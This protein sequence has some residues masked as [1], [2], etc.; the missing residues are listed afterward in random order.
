MKRTITL[1]LAVAATMALAAC[2]T[3]GGSGELPSKPKP[4]LAARY[5]AQLASNYMNEGRMDLARKKLALAMQQAPDLAV[6]HNVLALY[7][8][9]LGHY[10]KADEQYRISLHYKPND[11]DTLNNYGVFLCNRGKP[12][13][14]LQYFMRAA[15]DLNYPTPDSALANAGLCAQ[16]IPDAKL[17]AKYFRQ[18]LAVNPNQPQ[19]LWQLGLA[20]FK[21]GRYSQANKYIT[22]LVSSRSNPSA[23]ALWVA[24]ET[25][26]TLGQRKQ[27]EAYGRELVKRYPNSPEA[28]KFIQLLSSGS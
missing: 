19:A 12:R 2:T 7:Y 15:D 8:S 10:E 20:A 17:A 6:V 27:A 16:K 9:R 24:I 5:N 14:S 26:W 28:N 13:A 21:Q 1:C 3:S 18:T 22:Q 11:P 23:Q 25:N 4:K